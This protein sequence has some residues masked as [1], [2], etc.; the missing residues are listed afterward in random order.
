MSSDGNTDGKS[1]NTLF[2]QR[3]IENSVN[4]VLLFEATCAPEDSTEFNILTEN[5]SAWIRKTCTWDQFREKCR[6]LS[7]L[8]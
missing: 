3:G 4:T 2:R 8:Q 1:C 6:W 5:F 7:W